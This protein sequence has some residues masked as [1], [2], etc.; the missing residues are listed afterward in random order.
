MAMPALLPRYTVDQVDEL[1]EYPGVRYE[2]LDGLLLVSP[3]PAS[4]HA[5]I[6]SRIISRCC[7]R[8]IW[9]ELYL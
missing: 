6:T 5:V 3:A 9:G 1:P 8:G 4:V 2:L 7:E